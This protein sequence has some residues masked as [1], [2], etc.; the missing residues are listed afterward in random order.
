MRDT[1]ARHVPRGTPQ[2]GR[3]PTPSA[4]EV[5]AAT[6]AAPTGRESPSPQEPHGQVNTPASSAP[7]LRGRTRSPPILSASTGAR[8]ARSAGS[9]HSTPCALGCAFSSPPPRVGTPSRWNADGLSAASSWSNSLLF[10]ARF[11]APP[12][13]KGRRPFSG[14]WSPPSSAASGSSPQHEPSASCGASASS[15]LLSSWPIPSRRVLRQR[16]EGAASRGSRTHRARHGR[17]LS[18]RCV[19][20]RAGLAALRFRVTAPPLSIRGGIA[21][22]SPG[23]GGISRTGSRPGPRA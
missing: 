23:H 14:G 13:E 12:E 2:P 19:A 3:E 8:V 18:P 17:N 16:R 9:R 6:D 15:L 22:P 10:S 4:G 7:P 1:R 5:R 21:P 20:K 11:F